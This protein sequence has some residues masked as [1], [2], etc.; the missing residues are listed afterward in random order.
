MNVKIWSKLSVC[1]GEIRKHLLVFISE[2]FSENYGF[3]NSLL[4]KTLS[5]AI[6]DQ[7]YIDG[8]SF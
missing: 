5:F 2:S 3:Q 4:R 8:D 1:T 6:S 7:D